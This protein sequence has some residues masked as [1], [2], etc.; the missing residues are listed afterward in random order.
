MIKTKNVTEKRLVN[1]DPDLVVCKAVVTGEYIKLNF[2][3]IVVAVFVFVIFV[4]DRMI[5]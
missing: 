5:D 1:T 2:P 4:T 3:V